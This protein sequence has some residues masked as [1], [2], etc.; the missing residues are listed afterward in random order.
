MTVTASQKQDWIDNDRVR[1]GEEGDGA[2]AERERRNGDECI[3]RVEVAA[4][5]EPSDDGAEAPTAEAPFVQQIEIAPA[6]MSSGKAQPRNEGKERHEDGEGGPV[7]F[8]HGTSLP[9][10][11]FFEF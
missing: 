5:Q 10:Y 7:H 3:G 9:L 4:D 6:P 1:H 8:G 2:S 11:R